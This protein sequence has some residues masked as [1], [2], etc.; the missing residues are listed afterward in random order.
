M[1]PVMSK[2]ANTTTAA[3]DAAY[4]IA[5]TTAVPPA[6]SPTLT[7]MHISPTTAIGEPIATVCLRVKF[8]SNPHAMHNQVVPFLTMHI[9]MVAESIYTDF[10]LEMIRCSYDAQLKMFITHLTARLANLIRGAGEFEIVSDAGVQ[11]ILIPENAAFVI[12]NRG[13]TRDRILTWTLFSQ[14]PRSACTESEVEEAIS[15]SC[16]AAKTKMTKFKR[17]YDLTT[18]IPKSQWHV[19]WAPIGSTD[20]STVYE[21]LHHLANV[22]LPDGTT[23]RAFMSPKVTIQGKLCKQCFAYGACLCDTSE[24]TGKCSGSGR[25]YAQSSLMSRYKRQRN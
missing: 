14:D 3:A 10:N 18:S 1:P 15:E 25:S 5:K 23:L 12:P 16:A 13:P 11:Y 6:G 19:D 2:P 8:T 17:S 20:I 22:R 24:R 7:P 21:N 4:K 9:Q